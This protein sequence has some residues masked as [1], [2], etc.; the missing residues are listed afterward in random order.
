MGRETCELCGHVGQ[1]WAV[2][3]HHIVPTELTSP[4]GM[5]DS[6]TATLCGDCHHEVHTWYSKRV[7]DLTYDPGLKRFRPRPFVETVKEYEAAYRIFAEY[8]KGQ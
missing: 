1:L 8:K 6:A 4:S 5:P 7:F 3:T 2:T